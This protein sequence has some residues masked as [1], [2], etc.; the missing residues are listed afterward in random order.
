MVLLVTTLGLISGNRNYSQEGVDGNKILKL[1]KFVSCALGCRTDG[2]FQVKVLIPG[3][4]QTLGVN[5]WK[6]HADI[7]SL[8]F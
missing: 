3:F 7:I 6:C 5:S 4:L 8:S 2:G 1:P